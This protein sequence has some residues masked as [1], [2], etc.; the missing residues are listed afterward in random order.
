[1]VLSHRDVRIMSD[2]TYAWHR[3]CIPI[4]LVGSGNSSRSS[5][6]KGHVNRRNSSNY[7]HYYY[8]YYWNIVMP[9]IMLK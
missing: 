9:A 4:M 2:D 3:I 6:Q 1:M 8:C 7:E 5:K